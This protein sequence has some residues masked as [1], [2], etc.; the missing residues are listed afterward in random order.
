MNYFGFNLTDAIL[1]LFGFYWGGLIFGMMY[2]GF[3]RFLLLSVFERRE[4]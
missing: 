3:I 4:G 1:G 2:M